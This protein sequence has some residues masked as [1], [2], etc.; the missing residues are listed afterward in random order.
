MRDK[1]KFTGVIITDD[2]NMDALD[3]IENKNVKALLAGNDLL[4]TAD[5][6]ESMKQ[7]KNALEEK[8]IDEN[9]IDKRVFRNLAWKY[10]KG[11][12]FQNK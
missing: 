3:S 5:Y 7:I 10:Y 9:L 6:E 12:M 1:L 4:I 2:L 11:L 8:V